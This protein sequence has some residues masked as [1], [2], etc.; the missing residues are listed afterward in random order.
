MQVIVGALLA[1]VAAFAAV[2]AVLG[3]QRVVAPPDLPVVSLIAAGIAVSVMYVRA[4]LTR[5]LVMNA[6]LRLAGDDEDIPAWLGVYQT[7][8]IVGAA[9]LEGAAFFLLT[10]Y[11][12]EGTSWALPAAAALW[13]LLAW[14]HFPTRSGVE[15]WL[16]EQL[17]EARREKLSR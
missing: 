6:R 7:V 8:T 13:L 12:I 3:P 1:G 17:D 14:L 9:L 10:A 15:H 4:V 16:T 2:V 5:A 11:F